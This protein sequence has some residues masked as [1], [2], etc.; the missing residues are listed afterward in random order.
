MQTPGKLYIVATPIGNMED[1]T[2]RAIAVLRQAD[3][4]AAEDTRQAARLFSFHDIHTPLIS[5]YEHNENSRI[6]QLTDRLEK[7]E[8]VALISEAG[9]PSV[10]DPGYRLAAAAIEKGIPVV[11]IPGV[12]AAITALSASGLAT[13]SFT[14]IG[15]VPKKEGKRLSLLH[16]LKQEPRTLIFYESP[17]R[18]IEFLA[19][20]TEVMGDRYGV[21]AR[22]MTK[23]YEEF[24]RGKLSYIR[25]DL[26]NRAAVKGECTLL[27]EGASDTSQG[28]DEESL[29][30]ELA[31][32]LEQKQNRLSAIV[33]KIA[34]KYGLPKNE[35]YAKALSLMENKPEDEKPSSD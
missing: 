31:H 34:V 12:S 27:V 20:L 35:V 16:S 28:M 17:R 32:E 23:P 25:E 26:E 14:F 2:L 3:V 22:E 10:S 7:G 19:E 11:P 8:S 1:I 30:R 6:P 13:D 29:C 33:K 4:A 24:I 18:I 9:T 21:L 15:F 5:F